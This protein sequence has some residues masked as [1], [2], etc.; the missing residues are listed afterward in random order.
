MVFEQFMIYFTPVLV[1]CSLIFLLSRTFVKDGQLRFRLNSVCG[2]LD[3]VKSFIV[4]L[5]MMILPACQYGVGCDYWSYVDIY[6]SNVFSKEILWGFVNNAFSSL[7]LSPQSIFIFSSVLMITLWVSAICRNS[8]IPEMS[9]LLFFFFD[10]YVFHV[11]G[12]LRQGI[13]IAIVFY[14][15][16]YIKDRDVIRFLVSITVAFGFHY[17]SLLAI[18]LYWL[19]GINCDYRLLGVLSCFVL[20]L[21][22]YIG[23]LVVKIMGLTY[24]GFYI[25]GEHDPGKAA[26]LGLLI[27]L[28]II[29]TGLIFQSDNHEYRFLMTSAFVVLNMM[30]FTQ[31]VPA[32]GRVAIYYG[33]Y[34]L[35][36]LP[37]IACNIRDYCLRVAYILS[38]LLCY[39]G[40]YVKSFAVMTL[41]RPWGS[42]LLTEYQIF[43][44][45]Y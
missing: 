2:H 42:A 24:Y 16:R 40:L 19:Y 29:I 34:M 9:I 32:F 41:E 3:L 4:G 33:V 27:P 23:E 10:Y 5:P 14:S 35:L 25:G 17:T 12:I 36:L 8:K 30:F 31:Y 13:A 15:Y 38:V 20:V 6:Q 26:F 21:R 1:T 18:P 11:F 7:G 39:G 37:A 43:F 22:S 28:V 45:M 44:G